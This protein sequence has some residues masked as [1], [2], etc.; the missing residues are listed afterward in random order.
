MGILQWPLSV[1]PSCYLLLNHWMKSN[2]IWCVSCSHEWGVQQHIFFGPVPWGR[3][4]SSNI[5]KLQLQSQFQIFLNQ[6]LCVFS[7]MKDIKHIRGIFIPSPGSGP[8]GRTS[9]GTGGLGA[10]NFFFLKFNQIWCMSTCNGTIF[11]APPP[12]HLERGQISLNSNF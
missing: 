12:P 4:K 6:T 10:H 7:Q 9:G 11:W 5:V 1:R 2:Q 8:R 3:T